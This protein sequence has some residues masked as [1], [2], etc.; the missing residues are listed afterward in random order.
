MLDRRLRACA[1]TTIEAE[2][3]KEENGKV[4]LK[5]ADG[6]VKQ[7]Q[8]SKLIKSDQLLVTKL[9]NPFY[10]PEKEKAADTVP[11]TSDMVLCVRLFLSRT[12]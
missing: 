7:I 1:G 12:R 5:T 8:K 3:V 4:H 6:K 9:S 10:D 11:C 2:F